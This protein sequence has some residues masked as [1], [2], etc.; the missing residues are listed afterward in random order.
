[1]PGFACHAAGIAVKI[2]PGG[3]MP[4]LRDVDTMEL[5]ATARRQ[6]AERARSLAGSAAHRL[7]QE[8]LTRY[9]EELEQQA[10]E[11]EA[12]IAALKEAF[13]GPSA[14]RP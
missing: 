14:A 11:L 3:D 8:A 4:S 10:D 13:A 5:L 7:G 6:G 9:A 2:A 12:Q 1:M